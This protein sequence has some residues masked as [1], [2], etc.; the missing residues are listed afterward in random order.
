MG[1]VRVTAKGAAAITVA[2]GAVILAGGVGLAAGA[3]WG[4]L[5]GI[6]A[7]LFALG[8]ATVAYGLFIVD[9]GMWAPRTPRRPA[10]R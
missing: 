4:M 2:V 3:A 8:G 9:T 5:A 6:A 7:G 1:R 10:G